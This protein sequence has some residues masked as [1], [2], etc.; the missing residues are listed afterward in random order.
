MHTHL[1]V[2]GVCFVQVGFTTSWRV[3]H[4]IAQQPNGAGC[5]SGFHARVR[6]GGVRAQRW[7]D[8]LAENAGGNLGVSGVPHPHPQFGKIK[9]CHGMRGSSLPRVH[10]E[11]LDCICE[12]LM[13]TVQNKMRWWWRR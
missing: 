8:V 10:L 7:D 4:K 6:N 1:G 5:I 12:H 9:K 2:Q 11:Q 3:Q 13:S